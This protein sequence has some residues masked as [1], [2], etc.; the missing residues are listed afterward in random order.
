[1]SQL[2]RRWR[3]TLQ[4]YGLRLLSPARRLDFLPEQT[5][6]I[7]NLYRMLAARDGK[8]PSSGEISG[9]LN[10]QISRQ[11]VHYHVR[12]LK[13]AGL[14]DGEVKTPD[15][16]DVTYLFGSAV[17]LLRQWVEAHP[18]SELAISQH[19][20]CTLLSCH[21][22]LTKSSLKNSTSQRYRSGTND[23]TRS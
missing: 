9:Y 16:H 11:T 5:V 19:S 12:K 20:C 23:R 21:R 15:Q 3:K 6:Q 10:D 1:M 14:I 17:C 2:L 13:L 8:P 4:S 18:T 22:W 7:Y